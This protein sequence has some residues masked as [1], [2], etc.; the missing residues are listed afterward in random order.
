[1]AQSELVFGKSPATLSDGSERCVV[2]QPPSHFV[3]GEV[4]SLSLSLSLTL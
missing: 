4:T 3:N 1:V 2:I